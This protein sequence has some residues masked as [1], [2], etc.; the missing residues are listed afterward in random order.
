MEIESDERTEQA[1]SNGGL[2]KARLGCLHDV[3]GYEVS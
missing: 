3:A 2:S 1:M